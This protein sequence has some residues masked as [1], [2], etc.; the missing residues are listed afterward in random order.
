MEIATPA[1]AAKYVFVYAMEKTPWLIKAIE[2]VRQTLTLLELLDKGMS[3]G[4]AA[5]MSGMSK[6]AAYMRVKTVLPVSAL[7]FSEVAADGK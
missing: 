3:F 7:D 6:T 4:N 1:K 2:Q 5:S